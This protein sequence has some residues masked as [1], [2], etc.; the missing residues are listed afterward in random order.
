MA[1]VRMGATL[2][3]RDA[4]RP[5][6]AGPYTLIRIGDISQDGTF[7]NTDFVRINPEQ[8]VSNDLVLRTGDVLFPNRGTR[9][10]SIVYRLEEGSAVAGSQFFIVRPNPK[11]AYPE[12]LAWFLRTEEMANYFDSRRK[13]S[14]VQLIERNDLVNVEVPL[15][16][17]SI[18]QKIVAAADLAL[19]ERYLSVKLAKLNW[20]SINERLVNSAKETGW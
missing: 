14:Y 2:R 7:I 10:T 9:T 16:P 3:G 15:P 1:E 12:Y 13:G 20:K 8:T 19:K 17:L 4:T 5:A 6:P 11:I 18:Q